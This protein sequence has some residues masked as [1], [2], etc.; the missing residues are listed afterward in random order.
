MSIEGKLIFPSLILCELRKIKAMFR[1]LFLTL[2]FGLQFNYSTLF[3]QALIPNFT[4]GFIVY[5]VKPLVNS[6]V[7]E[8]YRETTVTLYIKDNQAKLDLKMLAGFVEIQ[9]LENA[10]QQNVALINCPLLSEK[11]SITLGKD[12][13]VFPGFFFPSNINMS[14]QKNLEIEI[15]NTDKTTILGRTG[16]KAI[17]PVKGSKSKA[18]MYL[19]NKIIIDTPQFIENYLGELNSLP[20]NAEITILGER[21]SLT[22]KE[23]RKTKINDKVFE[24]PADY[25]EKSIQSFRSE[26]DEFFGESDLGT[27][28]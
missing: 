17:V 27:G 3:A 24:V 9:L 28:L 22:A 15:F 11:S 21:V 5:D 14:P 23:I 16:Y 4:E 20:L 2:F 1:F 8:L 12:D 10:N 26:I 7:P 19:S 13:D 25:K 6:S 18:S